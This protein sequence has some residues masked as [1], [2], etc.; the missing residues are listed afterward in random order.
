MS[1]VSVNLTEWQHRRPNEDPDLRGLFLDGD[2][3][4]R[5]LAQ[6]LT[7]SNIL[8]VQELRHGLSLAATSFVGRIELG[9]LE[10]TIRPKITGMRLACLLRYAYGLRDLRLF[11]SPRYGVQPEAFQDLLGCQLAAEAHE[12]LARGLHRSYIRR[13]ADLGSPRGRIDLQTLAAHG[14]TALAALPCIHHPRLDNCLVN[15]VL[16]AGLHLATRVT[17]DVA[18]R[19]RLRS[20]AKAL[21][22]TVTAV[23]L[24]ADTLRR[25]SRTQNRLTAAYRPALTIIRLL[26][27]GIGATLTEGHHTVA[28]PG[29][30]FDMNRFFQALLSRFMHENLEGCMVRDECSLRHMLAYVPDHNPLNRRAPQPRPDFV[31][32]QGQTIAAVLDAKYRDLWLNPLPREMLYQLAMYA[33]AHP[34]CC[35]AAILYPCLE[36]AARESWIAINSPIGNSRP[37]R[38]V[39]RPVDLNRLADLLAAPM[40]TAVARE[41]QAL[42]RRLALGE[43]AH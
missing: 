40:T 24:D 34:A 32:V 6:S 8:Q 22:Q 23:R 11:T 31:I 10:I 43:K 28:L 12:L 21:E 38:I 3:G 15:E 13:E 2:R 25:L 20:L 29:F 16:L 36:P 33:L 26:L 27:Q 9:P 14:G 18:L 7:A 37:G 39:L 17:S 42:A 19:C 5:E 35:F 41:K 30:M 4:V 1:E